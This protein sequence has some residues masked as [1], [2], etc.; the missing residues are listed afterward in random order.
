MNQNKIVC[1]TC[2]RNAEL[3][4][5]NNTTTVICSQCCTAI[6]LD[7]YREL[8]ENWVNEMTKELDDL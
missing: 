1:V 2:K 3:M 7:T 5:S 4:T 6:E 8:F